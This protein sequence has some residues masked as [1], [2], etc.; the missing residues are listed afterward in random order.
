MFSKLPREIRDMIFEEMLASGQPQ[1]LRTSKIMNQEGADMIPKHG[2]LRIN[3][4]FGA[5]I[6]H[7]TITQKVADTVQNLRL[8]VNMTDYISFALGRYP[9]RAFPKMLKMFSNPKISRKSC[10]VFFEGRSASHRLI[11]LEVVYSLKLLKEFEE[12]TLSIDASSFGGGK[13]T[14]QNRHVSLDIA[15]FELEQHL[16]AAYRVKEKVGPQLV[17]Y[18]RG[19]GQAVVKD[20]AGK[21][22]RQWVMWEDG[23]AYV[24]M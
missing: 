5:M 13:E 14:N 24:A 21:E 23:K 19:S 17:F 12:V 15:Y 10:N 1:F 4:G 8:R 2:V 9:E 18:P 11:A 20:R 16:G 22:K 7:P 3:I 6:S